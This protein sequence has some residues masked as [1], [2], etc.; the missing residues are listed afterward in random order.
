VR[1]RGGPPPSLVANYRGGGGGGQLCQFL[2]DNW[3]SCRV[4]STKQRLSEGLYSG[5]DRRW[6]VVPSGRGWQAIHVAQ[7]TGGGGS[8]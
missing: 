2:E 8:T 4:S 3:Q 7:D 1:G 5:G 6:R